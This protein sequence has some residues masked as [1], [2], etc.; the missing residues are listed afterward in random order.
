MFETL[1]S[2]RIRRALLEHTLTHPQEPFYLRGLAKQLNLSISPLRR[3]LLR[4][5][6]AGMLTAIE[7]GNMR[8]YR[9][10]TTSPTFLELTKVSL[11]P[12]AFS[13]HRNTYH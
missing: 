5:E 7:E 3:E 9:V 4:L 6:H 1:V 2:S 10:N 12:S 8:F 11:Q 13:R